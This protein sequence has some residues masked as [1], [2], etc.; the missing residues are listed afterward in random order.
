MSKTKI[1]WADKTWNTVT[2]CT[3][4]SEGCLNCYAERVTNRFYPDRNFSE[5]MIHDSRLNQPLNWKKPNK[6]FV[7]SMSDLFHGL[8]SFDFI[9]EVFVTITKA[10][11]HIFIVLTKR[12]E[13][14]KEFFDAYYRDKQ[15]LMNVWLG[16]TTENQQTAEERIP[17]LLE[18]PAAKRFISVE[19][20]LGPINVSR[21]LKWPLCKY[22]K[23][24][25]LDWVICGGES[26]PGARP[27]HPDWVRGLRDQCRESGV[28]FLFKQWGEWVPPQAVNKP[29]A[30]YDEDWI[31]NIRRFPRADVEAEAN[32]ACPVYRVGKKAAGRSLDGVIHDEYPGDISYAD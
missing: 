8:V 27:I 20:I 24:V 4:V 31:N 19:P 13:R 22:W 3:K 32:C 29:T 28:P 11:Q 5:I 23:K 18:I 30:G 16:V 15:P 14:M 7:C 2:G 6:I 9:R 26:G 17:L 21:Y 25:G 12:P 10:P 1:E